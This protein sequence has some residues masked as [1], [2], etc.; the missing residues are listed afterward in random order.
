MLKNSSPDTSLEIG[1]ADSV[2]KGLGFDAANLNVQDH[3]YS[4]LSDYHKNLLVTLRQDLIEFMIKLAEKCLK[5]YSNETSI[6][7]LIARVNKK[8]YASKFKKL[9]V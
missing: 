3:V 8:K 4:K 9:N 6:L 2:N 1:H 5:F 7:M